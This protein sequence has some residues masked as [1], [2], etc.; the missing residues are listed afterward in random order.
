MRCGDVRG[1]RALLLPAA[2]WQAGKRSTAHTL[3]PT[4]C[5]H[6]DF[7]WSYSWPIH[8]TV[9]RTHGQ[10]PG[11]WWADGG[12]T[13]DGAPGGGGSLWDSPRVWNEFLSR[14]LRAALG[15]GA[16]RWV[17]PICHGF[18]EQRPLALLGRP[19]TLTLVARRSRQVR[20][21]GGS[22]ARTTR[23][24]TGGAALAGQPLPAPQL[25]KPCACLTHTP[26]P[27]LAAS[28]SHPPHRSIS[29]LCAS[30]CRHPLP[31][32]RRERGRRR[33]QRRGGGAGGRVVAGRGQA[34][35][36]QA[37]GRALALPSTG[38]SSAPAAR[39]LL[40]A[41]AAALGSLSPG[42]PSALA[43]AQVVEAGLDWKTGSPLL[44]S[45][46]QVRPPGVHT[47]WPL[48][49]C[50]PAFAHPAPLA[51]RALHLRR[52]LATPVPPASRL[53]APP[54]PATASC[55][56][57]RL[58]P[59]TLGAAPRLVGAQARDRAAPLG[60]ALRRHARAL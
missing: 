25:S 19:L 41:G 16:H 39:A 5:S 7:Y 2:C 27:L 1:G 38:A 40:D 17:V 12:G 60:P 56:G 34:G 57:A 52:P 36:G 10:A 3:N 59:A 11:E 49:Q 14:P 4:P 21:P 33:G 48:R 30:V 54:P 18:F 8:Q 51:A 58:H 35:G 28:R 44:A 13:A 31:Q 6:Q 32:A 22:G 45:V 9:Q 43:R 46:V 15:G 23:G 37:W 53:R 42:R 29:F 55:A 20:A 26:A 24:L 47:G 50:S